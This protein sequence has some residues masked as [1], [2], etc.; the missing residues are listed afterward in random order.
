MARKLADRTVKALKKPDTNYQITY[1]TKLRGFGVRVTKSGVKSFILNY[2]A[3]GRERRFTIGQYPQWGAEAARAEAGRLRQHID[4]GGDPVAERKA[5]HAE[6]FVR[7]L[8]DRYM[9]DHAY[10]R[11][12]R[13]SVAEDHRLLYE[14]IVPEIGRLKVAAVSHEDIDRFHRKL[15]ANTP[16]QA[17]RV[18]ALLS[19][20]FALAVKWRYR[21]DNP[22]QGVVRNQETQ[23]RRYLNGDE[24]RR[25]SG[26]LADYPYME[27]VKLKRVEQLERGERSGWRRRE[28]PFPDRLQSANAIRLL[29]LTGARKGELLAAKWR[30]IDFEAGAWSK[31]G[32]TT[33]QTTEHRVPLSAP[34]LQLL[35]GM[36]QTSEYV[37]PGNGGGPQQDLKGAW[38]ALRKMA[39]IEDVRI[40]DLRH[41]YAA[42]LASA[43]LSLPVIGALLGHTQAATTQRYAHLQDDPLREA[44][45]RVG[46]AYVSAQTGEGAEVVDLFER[47]SRNA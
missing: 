35:A 19:K 40:H 34:A 22:T 42:Q 24:L 2:V 14:V 18:L 15:S 6:P 44:T 27:R 36:E 39:E 32:A 46:A 3:G 12:R 9:N 26:A 29:L 17:N 25:L 47:D 16:T 21:S 8:A 7:D 43:G 10:P 20:M 4:Q 23:R 31:P 41:T 28:R 30:D 37:F 45:E 33:K 1:D 5:K 11:K 13:S 38:A